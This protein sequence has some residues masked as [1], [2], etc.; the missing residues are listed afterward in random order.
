MRRLVLALALTLTFGLSAYADSPKRVAMP[1]KPS[2][3]IRSV[4]PVGVGQPMVVAMASGFYLQVAGDVIS[5]R[6]DPPQGATTVKRGQVV[7]FTIT[8]TNNL[9]VR[10]FDLKATA[11]YTD[12]SGTQRTVES[13]T[14]TLTID[15]SVT[16]G[17]LSLPVTNLSN[18]QLT[19]ANGNPVPNTTV[20][21]T[22]VT[23]ANLLVPQGAPVVLKLTGTIR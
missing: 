23:V 7:T 21:N 19:D 5:I 4:R 11:T 18:V 8:I 9:P 13:N 20:T 12:S 6:V 3:T 10:T 2:P 1:P 14:V 22:G 16:I 17:T 15:E